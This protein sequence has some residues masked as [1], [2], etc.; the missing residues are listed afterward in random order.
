MK[1]NRI[2]LINL[3]LWVAIATVG[4]LV[5]HPPNATPL[6]ALAILS[7]IVL[8]KR[9][10]LGLVLVSLCLSDILL[11]DLNH[12]AIWG[13]WSFFTYSGYLLTALFASREN[14]LSS[15]L[16][17]TVFATFGY[18]LWTNLG[19]WL[20]GV[21]YAYSWQG[22]AECYLAAVPFLRNAVI[23][24]LIYL[25]LLW[26]ALQKLHMTVNMKAHKSAGKS[27]YV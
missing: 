18:W 1:L 9:W 8:P 3:I 17:Y 14:R 7:V 16:S 22:L 6:A 25:V 19:T 4:R 12:T 21:I 10:A 11:S 23:G 26:F 15:L 20:E 24:N 27:E 5:P 13:F 2:V